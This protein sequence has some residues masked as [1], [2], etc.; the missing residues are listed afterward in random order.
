MTKQIS[1]RF[2]ATVEDVLSRAEVNRIGFGDRPELTA[3]RRDTMPLG[4]SCGGRP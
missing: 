4:K 2:A 3:P 1:T